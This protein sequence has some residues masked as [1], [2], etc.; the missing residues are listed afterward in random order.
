[1]NLKKYTLSGLEPA[2]LPFMKTFEL[3]FVIKL[4]SWTGPLLLLLF[5]DIPA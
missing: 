4:G 1:V 3:S 5:P 2:T